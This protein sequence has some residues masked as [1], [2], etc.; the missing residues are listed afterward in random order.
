MMLSHQGEIVT[1]G[2]FTRKTRIIDNLE[3]LPHITILKITQLS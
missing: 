1:R 2:A 3:T